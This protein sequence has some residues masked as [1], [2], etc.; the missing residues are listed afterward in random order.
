VGQVGYLPEWYEDARSDYAL[1]VIYYTL[2]SFKL[3]FRFLGW[4]YLFSRCQLIPNNS[5]FKQFETLSK[6]FKRPHRTS[7]WVSKLQFI[8]SHNIL[9]PWCNITIQA[10]KLWPSVCDICLNFVLNLHLPCASHMFSCLISVTKL[11]HYNLSVLLR[12]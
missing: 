11:Q 1:L 9:K 2:L 8:F 10:S 4:K 3:L 6:C 5:T 7:F 12:K